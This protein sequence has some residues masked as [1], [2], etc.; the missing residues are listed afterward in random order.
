MAARR[1]RQ[2]GY[3][4]N[5]RVTDK[6]VS[7]LKYPTLTQA[8]PS[9]KASDSDVV[10]WPA[11][12]RCDPGYRRVAQGIGSCCGHGYGGCV[13][14][15]ASTE[16]VVHG[17]AE[18]WVG[19]AL[20]A[21]IYALS[22]CEVMGTTRAGYGDGSFGSACAKAVSKYGVLHYGVDYK[23]EKFTEYSAE[24]EKE[25]G[26]S[27]VPDHLEPFAKKR[28]VKTV[29]L[30]ESF[31]DLCKALSSGF[32][33]AVCST[34][35][36]TMSRSDGPNP[37]DRGW[38]KPRGEWPHCMALIGFRGGKRPG[39]LV[40]NSWGSNAHTGGHYSGIPDRPDDMPKE[41]RGSTFWADAD[42]V[43][44]MLRQQDSFA[45]SSYDGFP[46]RKIPSWTGGV[47]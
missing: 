1:Q 27:G 26:N 39:A 24:R 19:R 31:D 42:V 47:L 29:T 20:E 11:I 25:W 45:L 38:A 14:A 33:T 10:L 16:I 7:A 12:L 15:L 37:E 43:D 4:P 40:W 3:T 5:P 2:F 28:L 13:D 8:N 21:S 41:F 36:F 18:D 23:G 46:A 22:R 34:Q 9:L 35:G 17:E 44:R 6:I 32:P 30:I